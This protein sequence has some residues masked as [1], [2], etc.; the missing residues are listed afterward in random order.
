MD[1]SSD[2]CGVEQLDGGS[3]NSLKF[4]YD[5]IVAYVGLLHY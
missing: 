5:V 3:E 2:D 4:A 1:G